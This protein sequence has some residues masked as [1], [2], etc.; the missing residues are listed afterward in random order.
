MFGD[1]LDTTVATVRVGSGTAFGRAREEGHRPT[2]E[3]RLGLAVGS[4]LCRR[5]R[6]EREGKARQQF[7][8]TENVQRMTDYNAAIVIRWGIKRAP[9][10]MKLDGRPSWD[11]AHGFYLRTL[12]ELVD[13][14]VE[15][16]VAP[17]R[18]AYK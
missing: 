10:A 3:V 7:S 2:G 5:S 15:V 12:G 4:G 18:S 1:D 16:S 13:G 8:E 14:D 9:K 11:G 6:E 17:R